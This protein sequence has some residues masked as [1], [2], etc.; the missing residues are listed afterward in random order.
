[1]KFRAFIA[2]LLM[3]MAAPHIVAAQE[4]NNPQVYVYLWDVTLSMR[5]PKYGGTADIWESTRK[6][7]IDQ[8]QTTNVSPYDTIIVCPFQECIITGTHGLKR[9]NRNSVVDRPFETFDTRQKISYDS[10]WKYPATN[11]GKRELIKKIESFVQPHHGLTNL[12]G[13]FKY[14]E[15]NYVDT[16]KYTTTIYMLTDGIDDF[17]EGQDENFIKYIKNKYINDV[18]DIKERLDSKK[19][20]VKYVRLT[21]AAQD[22]PDNGGDFTVIDP[23]ERMC[24]YTVTSV[25]S[26]NFRNAQ[27]TNKRTHTFNVVRKQSAYTALDNADIEVK[28]TSEN[29]PFVKIDD[30]CKVVDGKIEVELQ[31]DQD[32]VDQNIFDDCILDI[33]FS[34][35]NNKIDK[36]GYKYALSFT[37]DCSNKLK[38]VNQVQ[39]VLKIKLRALETV[40]E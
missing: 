36:D 10:P 34:F 22:V 17:N 33:K 15:S 39:K 16:A 24:E 27:E 38:L 5:G 25:G 35:V 32:V 13:P 3:V 21:S 9:I 40:E 2:A 19:H 29:N 8:I 12:L 26:F 28:V 37:A 7:L 18:K 20:L 14:A 30:I 23:D 31:Y 1:M 11:N 6:W 4:N